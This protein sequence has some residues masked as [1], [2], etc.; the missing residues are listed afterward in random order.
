MG[1]KLRKSIGNNIELEHVATHTASVGTATAASVLFTAATTGTCTTYFEAEIL[2]KDAWTG[3]LS[4]T[5]VNGASAGTA[6][7]SYCKDRTVTASANATIAHTI[8]Y[9]SSGTILENLESDAGLPIR[10]R[11][12]ILASG[13]LYLIYVTSA[14]ASNSIDVNLH[15]W[16]D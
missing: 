3:T 9:A 16:E 1:T 14:G 7:I 8:T 5:S 4:E 2:S 13:G 6:I 11:R 15:F 12:Y 10:T